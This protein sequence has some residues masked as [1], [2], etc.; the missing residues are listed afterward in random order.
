VHILEVS[1][2]VPALSERLLAEGTLERP[3]PRV[4][5]EMVAKVTTLLK[6]TPATHV[7]AFE[8]Q[9][10]SLSLGIPDPYSLVPL[11]GHSF[12]SFVFVSP[13]VANFLELLHQ[14]I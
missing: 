9:L 12:E 14:L 4:L 13:L 5:S 1:P 10:N 3:H 6:Y 11:F 8:V 7:L 2:E